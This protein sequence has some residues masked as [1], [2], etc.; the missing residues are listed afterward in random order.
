MP[1]A[2][3]NWSCLLFRVF[4]RRRHERC[5]KERPRHVPLAALVKRLS[6]SGAA[7]EERAASG[8][9]MFVV[10]SVGSRPTAGAFVAAPSPLAGGGSSAVQRNGLGEGE[11]GL[12]T[13]PRLL[14]VSAALSR[15]G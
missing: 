2:P 13:R 3:R 7:M 9:I 1:L 8:P 4:V 6:Q 11:S 12:L 5:P 15:K 10:Q 14:S